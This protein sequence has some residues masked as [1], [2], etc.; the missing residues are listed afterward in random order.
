M[1]I[2]QMFLLLG[3]GVFL[4][5]CESGTGDKEK[6]TPFSMNSLDSII[7]GTNQA[8]YPISGTCHEEGT[9]ITVTVNDTFNNTLAV[10]PSTPPTCSSKA[11]ST[12]VD[13]SSLSDGTLTVV[14]GYG[15]GDFTQEK[16]VSKDTVAPT[17]RVSSPDNIYPST[18]NAYGI[19]G[20]CSENQREVGL[21]KLT[22]HSI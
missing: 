14:A 16:T 17:I 20:T 12:T 15:E 1:L 18:K 2:Q 9:V 7:V 10:E 13:V 5:S 21:T 3:L 6:T 11:W 4:A 22:G 19:N 8:T